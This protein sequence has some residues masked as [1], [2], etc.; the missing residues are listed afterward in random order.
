MPKML[1]KHLV[2]IHICYP[3]QSVVDPEKSPYS[4]FIDKVIKGV[5]SKVPKVDLYQNCPGR[6]LKM[7]SWTFMT[8]FAF[9]RSGKNKRNEG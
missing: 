5:K 1:G 8:I 6:L 4:Q 7:F 3:P 9:N 2:F